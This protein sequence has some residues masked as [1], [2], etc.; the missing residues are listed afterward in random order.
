MCAGTTRLGSRA[1]HG[2]KDFRR[3]DRE[4]VVKNII[5]GMKDMTV[6]MAPED[7]KSLGNPSRKPYGP[8]DA[9]V[10]I[11]E[12]H[13]NGLIEIEGA[14]DR[15]LPLSRSRRVGNHPRLDLEA[16]AV[17]K[18][19]V[20]ALLGVRCKLSGQ[21]RGNEVLGVVA[22]WSILSPHDTTRTQL[23]ERGAIESEQ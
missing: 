18:A 21:R 23:G 10:G 15:Q 22:G 5:G 16:G 7:R 6:D 20:P 11:G 13:D 14:E 19:N 17:R 9:V 1:S 2:T 8:P 12:E 3:V 4:N